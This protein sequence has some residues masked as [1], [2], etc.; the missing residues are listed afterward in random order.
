MRTTGAELVAAAC[1]AALAGCGGSGQPASQGDREWIDNTSGVIDQ[2]ERD[3]VLQSGGA[4]TVAA[5]REE[6]RGGLYTL[7]VA[8]TD[9]GGC[10]HMVSAAGTA[11][12]RFS[13]VT[14]S[15]DG[16]CTLLERAA[17]L[18][19]HAATANDATALV[20]AGRVASQASPLLVRAKVGLQAAAT[21]R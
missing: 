17:A 14:Q 3:L 16:A 21:T 8:Y 15:L 4:D 20:Q 6:L 10:R 1:L 18:F 19:T 7:L 11:P 9:F 13:H 2:L 5:A 12:T